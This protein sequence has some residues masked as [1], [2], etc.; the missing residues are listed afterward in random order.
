MAPK[1]KKVTKQKVKKKKWVSIIAPKSFKSIKLGETHVV[2][3]QT[4]I[5]RSLK[6]NLMNITGSFKKQ[7]IIVRFDINSVKDGKAYTFVSGFENSVSLMKRIVRKGR[8]KI[9]DSFLAKTKDGF[10]VRVKPVVLTLNRASKGAQTSIRKI[11]KEKLIHML[12]GIDFDKA[13]QELIDY[14]FQK[15]IKEVS[16]T[17]H[18]VKSV[19]VRFLAITP[20]SKKNTQIKVELPEADEV[21][22]GTTETP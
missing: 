4:I 11:V 7:N 13:V 2:D 15:L 9:E 22:S 3:P 12:S 1:K 5:G 21:K 17:I 10:S 18:P 14:N 16:S 6:V 20:A 19:E 8:T